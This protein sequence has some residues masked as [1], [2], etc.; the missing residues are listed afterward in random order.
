MVLSLVSGLFSTPGHIPILTPG[1]I[2]GLTPDITPGFSSGLNPILT[3]SVVLSHGH[4]GQFPGGPMSIGPPATLCM[5]C[6]ACF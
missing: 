3:T 5:L 6:T 2:P 1:L 4:T